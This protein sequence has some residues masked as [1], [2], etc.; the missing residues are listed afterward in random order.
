MVST[1]WRPPTDSRAMRRIAVSRLPRIMPK[2][3][4]GSAQRAWGG[5]ASLAESLSALLEGQ[6]PNIARTIAPRAR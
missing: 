2:V 5:A 1:A 4:A 3:A 6:R